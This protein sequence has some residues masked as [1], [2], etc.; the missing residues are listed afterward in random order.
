MGQVAI[1]AKIFLPS[2]FG[3]GIEGIVSGI[4]YFLEVP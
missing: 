2:Y 1:F 4:V 3:K